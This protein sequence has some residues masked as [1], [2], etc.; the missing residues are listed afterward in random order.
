MF[1][2]MTSWSGIESYLTTESTVYR[3]SFPGYSSLHTSNIFLIYLIIKTF[4]FDV[5]ICFKVGGKTAGYL[6][7]V[8]NFRQI[9]MRNAGKLFIESF[10]AWNNNGI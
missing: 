6:K 5:S 7:K 3:V 2:N 4:Y 9:V 8:D 10:L 1:K